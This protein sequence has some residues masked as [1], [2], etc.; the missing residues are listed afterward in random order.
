MKILFIDLHNLAVRRNY[1]V[2][3]NSR[4]TVLYFINIYSCEFYF[5]YICEQKDVDKVRSVLL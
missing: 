2:L 3:S 1:I 5:N 4:D